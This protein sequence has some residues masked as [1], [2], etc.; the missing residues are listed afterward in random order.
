MST[1]QAATPP[2]CCRHLQA[3]PPPRVPVNRKQ[4]NRAHPFLLASARAVSPAESG[5]LTNSDRV[6]PS[7][8]ADAAA[9][10]AAV[11][12]EAAV[13]TKASAL[14]APRE[15]AACRLVRCFQKE[16]FSRAPGS[17]EATCGG[18]GDSGSR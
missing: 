8:E 14:T 3:P 4:H 15:A 5:A 10:A 9:A 16:G 2:R 18:E 17:A 7:P 6:R 11:C 1:S 12:C 13:S